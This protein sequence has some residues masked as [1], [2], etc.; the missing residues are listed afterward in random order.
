M[1]VLRQRRGLEHG[2]ASEDEDI[3]SMAKQDVFN[4]I[5]CVGRITWWI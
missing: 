4:E 3:M 5:L 2:D 1:E